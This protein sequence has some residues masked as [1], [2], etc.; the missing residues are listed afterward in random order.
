M[1]MSFVDWNYNVSFWDPGF[2]PPNKAGWTFTMIKFFVSFEIWNIIFGV[3]VDTKY[4]E[5]KLYYQ[6]ITLII[7]VF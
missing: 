7:C 3:N 2:S 6:S 4:M 1:S 5:S